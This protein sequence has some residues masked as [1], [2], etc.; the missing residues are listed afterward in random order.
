MQ[1]AQCFDTADDAACSI[2]V[3]NKSQAD[4]FK[5]HDGPTVKPGTNYFEVATAGI[6]SF[7]AI[8]SMMPK[9]HEAVNTTKV[10]DFVH[11]I[12]THGLQTLPDPCVTTDT[13][14]TASKHGG[15]CSMFYLGTGCEYYYPT[16]TIAHTW[17]P[18]STTDAAQGC[19]TTET[20]GYTQTGRFAS[21]DGTAAPISSGYR[22][23]QIYNNWA[24]IYLEYQADPPDPP[25]PP[26]L[27]EKYRLGGV[28]I[29]SIPNNN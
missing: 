12:T 18:I 24:T 2:T 13:R 8:Q 20:P 6:M 1:W 5:Y 7:A 17:G 16:G 11:R 23:P 15:T 14:E 22:V 9:F 25:D 10:V 19:V 21:L 4:P 28:Q 26:I 29:K 3:G 27:P